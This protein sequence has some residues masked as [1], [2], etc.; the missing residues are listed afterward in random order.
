[1]QPC[2]EGVRWHAE[3]GV[4]AAW[5]SRE[6]HAA[7][8]AWAPPEAF[9]GGCLCVSRQPRICSVPGRRATCMQIQH[10]VR[11]IL[12]TSGRAGWQRIGVCLRPD[13]PIALHAPILRG[14]GP[15]PGPDGLSH[16]MRVSCD[17]A[18]LRKTRGRPEELRI[19]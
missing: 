18:A 4:H 10:M 6:R 2:R 14:V 16:A 3:M 13:R 17:N 5:R 11:P 9:V 15:R 1:M 8:V 7:T 19:G 12:R